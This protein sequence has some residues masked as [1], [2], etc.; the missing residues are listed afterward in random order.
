MKKI[1]LLSILLVLAVLL[2]PLAIEA[3][4]QE[5]PELTAVVPVLNMESIEQVVQQLDDQVTQALPQLE[6]HQMVLKLARGEM[7]WNINEI[8]NGLI[9]IFFNELLSN[10]LLLSQ[11]IVLSIITAVL[12]NLMNSF[13]QA[14]TGKLAYFVC[15]LVL[16]T[17]AVGT[18]SLA[19]NIGREAVDH[20]VIFVLALLPMLLVLL[21]ALGGVI[22][23]GIFHPIILGSIA[24]VGIIVKDIILPLVFFAAILNVLNGVSAKFNVSKLADLLTSIAMLVMGLCSTVFMGVL[25][26]Q[27]VTGAVSDGVALRTAKY[28]TG[29][30]IPVVGG[31]FA[32]A[33]EAVVGSALLMKN[34]VGLAGVVIIVLLTILP[35]LKI[36]ALAFVY[37]LA[38]ALIQPTGDEQMANCLTSLANSLMLVFGAVAMVGLLFFFAVTIVV[39]MGNLTVMLR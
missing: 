4:Q 20:M 6:F 28:T 37:R 7:A 30:F 33:L 13:E 14:T 29:A 12:Q 1:I 19:I 31:M 22:S 21:A 11:L 18:F 15:Y 23:V 32:D 9:K 27:G 5:D 39:G 34:A 26:V 16:V 10:L 25:A 3:M 17:L 36:L 2:F 8:F 35:L 38:G 24:V